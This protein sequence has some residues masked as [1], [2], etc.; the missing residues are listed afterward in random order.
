MTENQF[1]L[2]LI[3]LDQM[4]MVSIPLMLSKLTTYNIALLTKFLIHTLLNIMVWLKGSTDT[5][6]K[7]P[8]LSSPKF[9]CLPPIGLMQFSLL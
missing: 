4:V 2:L 6:L 3:P 5:L 9:P 1:L 7:P 8:L